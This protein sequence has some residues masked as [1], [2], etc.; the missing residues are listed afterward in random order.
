MDLMYESKTFN[1]IYQCGYREIPRD[2]VRWDVDLVL[3][4]A[5]ECPPLQGYFDAQNDAELHYFPN[6]DKMVTSASP[7]YEYMWNHAQPAVKLLVESL[8]AGK[9]A[10]V[11]CSQGINRSSV[12]T[13]LAM[14]ELSGWSGEKVVE[15][16]QTAR[17]GTLCNSAFV[18]MIIQE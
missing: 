4:C 17:S 15:K 7:W 11:C 18:S 10:I 14:K 16:I 3:Y 6:E 1:R 12:V 8:K 13:G 2:L 9:T 5:A